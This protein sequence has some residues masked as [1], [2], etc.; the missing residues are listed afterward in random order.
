MIL[1]AFGIFGRTKA[2]KKATHRFVITSEEEDWV[3]NG[4]FHG[5]SV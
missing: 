4:V 1:E 2:S 5:S 3:L